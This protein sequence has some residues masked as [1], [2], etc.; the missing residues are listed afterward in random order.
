MYIHPSIYM[1][2]FI[3]IYYWSFRMVTTYYF[4]QSMNTEKWAKHNM[5][6]LSTTHSKAVTDV[7]HFFPMLRSSPD[8]QYILHPVLFSLQDVTQT[9]I[10]QDMSSLLHTPWLNYSQ[11]PL[12]KAYKL[13]N[14]LKW[15]TQIWKTVVFAATTQNQDQFI[16]LYKWTSLLFLH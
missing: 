10:P 11:T 12:P 1:Y 7:H 15:I 3:L 6:S 4:N 14:V 16:N 13:H 9:Y 8:L 2:L 5:K